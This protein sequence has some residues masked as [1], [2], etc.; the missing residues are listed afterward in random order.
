MLQMLDIAEGLNYLHTF[1][2]KI[3]HGDIKG[4]GSVD[5]VEFV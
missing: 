1:T 5:L 4:V 3:I 2:P